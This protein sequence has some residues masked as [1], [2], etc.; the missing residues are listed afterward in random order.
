MGAVALFSGPVSGAILM[1]VPLGVSLATASRRAAPSLAGAALVGVTVV[2][3]VASADGLLEAAFGWALLASAWLVLARAFLPRPT[4]LRVGLAATAGAVATAFA[5]L[6]ATGGWPALQVA[7]DRRLARSMMAAG[8]LLRRGGG[9]IAAREAADAAFLEAVQLQTLIFPAALALA[10]LAALALAVMLSAD[11]RGERGFGAFR[12][13]RFGPDLVWVLIAGLVGVVLPL[14]AVAFRVGANAIAF[15]AGLYALR[16]LAVVVA[17][18]SGAS[19]TA[20]AIALVL[21]VVLYPLAIPA[22]VMIGFG[23]TWLDLRAR[24]KAAKANEE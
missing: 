1:A 9:E 24:W 12:E 7:L 14:G 6:W 15:M 8:A 22:T 23:D 2:G 18:W 20:W 17:L 21:G 19:P 13:F 16:G 10:T 5:V 11:A 3:V 4:P